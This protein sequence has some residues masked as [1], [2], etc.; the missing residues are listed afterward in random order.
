MNEQDLVLATLE[1][2]AEA[3]CAKDLDRLMRIF[4]DGEGI[5][6]IGTGSDE[7][8]SG[9]DAVAAIFE[10][11]FA[12]ATATLFEWGWKCVDIHGNSATVA[13]ALKI[14]LLIGTESLVV[15][16]RWTVSLVSTASGWKWV[17]RHAS[18]AAGSQDEGSAYP[19]GDR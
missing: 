6:L 2:Y 7:L 9:R 17:H 11:N 19:T 8:C 18:A 12:E 16:I 13:I 14:H 1:E 3:Y 10:R 5:S 15:P 4:I